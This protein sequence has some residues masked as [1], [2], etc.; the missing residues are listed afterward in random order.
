MNIRS[1]A[2]KY[3][4]DGMHSIIIFESFIDGTEAIFFAI[5]L[6]WYPGI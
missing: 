4:I 5:V 6:L 3:D 2:C 1:V